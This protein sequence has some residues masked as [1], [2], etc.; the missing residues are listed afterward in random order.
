MQKK[1]NECTK[2]ALVLSSV[3]L[4]TALAARM[5]RISISLS[6]LTHLA[7]ENQKRTEFGG[8]S[9]SRNPSMDVLFTVSTTNKS[10]TTFT[11]RGRSV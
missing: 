10:L 4:A 6:G 3:P 1:S 7:E 2:C 11:T 5:L 9:A 8:G